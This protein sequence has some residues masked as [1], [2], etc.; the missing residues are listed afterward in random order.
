VLIANRVA[1]DL[2]GA[3]PGRSLSESLAERS[4]L[5]GLGDLLAGPARAE[6]RTGV[7]LQGGEGDGHEWTVVRVPLADAGDAAAL[8]VVEDVTEI[9]R[10]RRLEAWAEMARLIAH[11]IKNPLTPIRLS[12]EHLREAWL[13]DRE[14]YEGVFDRCTDN[15]L[16]QVE[17]LRSIASDFSAYAQIPRIERQ[18]GDLVAAVAVVAEAYRAAPPPGVEVRFRS[19]RDRLAA[20]FDPKLLPR[21]VRNLL[22]NAIRASGGR[23]CVEVGVERV[24]GAAVIT[25]SDQGPGVP[26]AQLG[27]IFEPYFSTHVTGTGLGLPIAAR[28]AEEHGGTLVAHNRPSG[29]FEVVVTIPLA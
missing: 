20:S 10:A 22:E 24:E 16:R 6:L 8:I 9:V 17:E 25:V 3:E 27:R 2:L 7:R 23:G 11:E 4:G 1:R 26:P 12:A 21:A 14:H 5:A 29:G 13:R 18:E 19:G 28:I 15:I